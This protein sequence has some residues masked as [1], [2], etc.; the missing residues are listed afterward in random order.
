[1]AAVPPL[2]TGAVVSFFPLG[3]LLPGWVDWLVREAIEVVMADMS[4]EVD[5]KEEVV[6]E[7][8]EGAVDEEV[9]VDEG[10]EEEGTEEGVE[11]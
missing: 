6:E 2:T 4:E 9:A 8:V 1:M 7:E 5:E 10:A 11:D 3:L